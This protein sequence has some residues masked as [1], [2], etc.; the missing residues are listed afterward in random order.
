[1]V[2]LSEVECYLEQQFVY[3]AFQGQ[4]ALVF[5]HSESIGVSFGV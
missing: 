4:Q 2:T 3:L 1:M 5:C